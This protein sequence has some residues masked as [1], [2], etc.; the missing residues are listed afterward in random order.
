VYVA[1]PIHARVVKSAF[2]KDE[3]AMLEKNEGFMRLFGTCD[4]S[5]DVD[6]LCIM[7]DTI[8]SKVSGKDDWIRK[9][10]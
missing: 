3:W 7:G 8:I 10:I 2:K 5:D 1:I 6:K 4:S 9:S